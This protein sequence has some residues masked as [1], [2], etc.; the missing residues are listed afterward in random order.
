MLHSAGDG[1]SLINGAPGDSHAL[2]IAV[3][4]GTS[5]APKGIAQMCDLHLNRMQLRPD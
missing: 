3:N 2:M 4:P 5:R 1:W